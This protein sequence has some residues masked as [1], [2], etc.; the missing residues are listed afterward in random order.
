MREVSYFFNFF[1]YAPHP[2]P[3]RQHTPLACPHRVLLRITLDQTDRRTGP[4]R[5]GIARR[6]QAD[7]NSRAIAFRAALA[8][9]IFYNS[10][11]CCAGHNNCCR[12]AIIAEP[13]TSTMVDVPSV[14]STVCLG[15]QL[16]RARAAQTNKA[17]R[18]G[19]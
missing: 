10:H 11:Y 18:K 6:P 7:A 5:P 9:M 1:N 15:A 4:E 8:L 3:Q 13:G 17:D 12:A 16:R 14:E 19:G 2:K